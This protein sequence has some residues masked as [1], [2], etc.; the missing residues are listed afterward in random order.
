[1]SVLSDGRTRSEGRIGRRA[2]CA[3]ALFAICGVALWA[4]VSYKRTSDMALFRLAETARALGRY[5]ELSHGTWPD[6]LAAIEH[7]DIIRMHD[8]NT[9][10]VVFDGEVAGFARHGPRGLLISTEE[11]SIGWNGLPVDAS[12]N[13][14][15]VRGYLRDHFREYAGLLSQRLRE[16]GTVRD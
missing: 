5:L 1:M 12:G 11:I 9:F 6:S 2:A 14:I 7:A 4:F 15:G 3:L 8:T 16:I 13:V 10:T